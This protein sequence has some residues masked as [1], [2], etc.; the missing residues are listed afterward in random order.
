MKPYP[1]IAGI[2]YKSPAPYAGSPGGGK[3]HP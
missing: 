2:C 1:F 3:S